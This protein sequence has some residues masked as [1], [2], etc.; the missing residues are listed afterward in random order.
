MDDKDYKITDVKQATLKYLSENP[1]YYIAI[2]LLVFGGIYIAIL[3]SEPRFLGISI[4]A[5]AF[6][7]I[8]VLNKMRGYLMKQFAQNL[9]YEYAPKGDMASV[10]GSLFEM[11]HSKNITHV[12]SGHD[13]KHNMRIFLYSFT[14]GYGKSS[15]TYNYTVFE[16]TFS[17]NMPH[18]SLK[19][20][21][22]VLGMTSW[23]EGFIPLDFSN[24]RSIHL[25]GDFDKHFFLDVEKEFEIEV[26]QIFSPDFMEKLINISKNFGFEFYQ[27]KL[28]IYTPKFINKMSE[29]TEMFSLCDEL[30]DR[31]E[32]VNK[33]IGDDVD[34]LREI[35][36]E[37]SK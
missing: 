31:I 7:V 35:I 33:R 11:G 30:S 25:E 26:Y 21:I 19:P 3:F 9:G 36:N 5:S 15:Y 20:K 1:I 34:S 27:N 23:P 29:I 32:P 22:S 12:I 18:I 8:F 17:G 6:L 10:S 13:D 4:A 28:Y 37:H 16:N 14:V 2:F 24:S